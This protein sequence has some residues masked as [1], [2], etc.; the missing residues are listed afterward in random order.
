MISR[1]STKDMSRE[2]WLNARRR[3]I[4]GSDAGALLGLNPYNSPYALWA[5]KTG[6]I[7]PEGIGDRE[8]VRLGNDLEQYVAE[9]WIRLR[10]MADQF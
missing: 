1:V 10:P 4:G 6:K 5:E 9:R 7:V 2:D 8:A 3:S